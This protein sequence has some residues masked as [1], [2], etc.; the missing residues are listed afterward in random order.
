MSRQTLLTLGVLIVTFGSGLGMGLYLGGEAG[1][2]AAIFPGNRT[3]S[4]DNSANSGLDAPND[5]H[6]D[7]L[8]SERVRELEK[9]LAEQNSNQA[10]IKADRLAFFKKYHLVMN[11]QPFDSNLEV[12]PQMADLLGLTKE[13]K[14]AVESHLKE[15][16]D[17]MDK[18]QDGDTT[19]SN[20][21]ANSVTYD[22]AADKQGEL[23]KHKLRAYLSGDIGDDRADA[24]LN[25]SEWAYNSQLA[26]FMEGKKEVAISWTQQNNQNQYTVTQKLFNAQGNMAGGSTIVG[27]SLQTEFQKY[28]PDGVKP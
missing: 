13:E 9:Q 19:L 10:S 27:N 20:Q 22:I 4:S 5:I 12:T 16:K 17:E 18:L 3:S 11:L 26:G 25:G 1:S 28:L 21:T 24:F 6:A 2:G 23:L 15:I 8:L 7:T 14:Q